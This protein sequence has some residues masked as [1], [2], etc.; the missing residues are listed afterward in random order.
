MFHAVAN[1]MKDLGDEVR[2]KLHDVVFESDPCDLIKVER[3]EYV[4][5][6]FEMLGFLNWPGNLGGM[7]FM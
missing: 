2:N 3:S 4:N 7:H 1:A 5:T 6:H